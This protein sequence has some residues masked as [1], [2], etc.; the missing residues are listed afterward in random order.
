[1]NEGAIIL[2]I[3]VLLCEA[4]RALNVRPGGKYVDCTVGTG[5]HAERILEALG[6]E[7]ALLG[8]DAD[9]HALAVAEKRLREHGSQV[10][11]VNANF[12]DLRKVCERYGFIPVKG[13]LFDLGTSS[14]QLGL[15]GRGFSFQHESPLD[16]R[17]NPK[18]NVTAAHIVNTFSED[19]LVDILEKYGEEPQSRAIARRIV[20]NRPIKTT[21]ELA[22]IVVS[23]VG[24]RRGRIHPSTR[25]FQSL[26]VAVNGELTALETALPQ[27]ID[28][29]APKGRVVAIS[30]HS[31]EDRIVKSLFQKESEG[32][33]CPPKIPICV[34]GHVPR[35][36]LVNRKAIMPTSEER[37]ANPRSRSARLRVTELI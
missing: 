25:T 21:T 19:K 27:A 12:R 5:G 26:R 17:F 22:R 11:L 30:Y 34:C 8:L 16:M 37:R 24:G 9:P 3:P 13:I 2:H 4:V 7:G 1:M 23:A 33:L 29:L 32:C 15:D 36:R 35:L 18:Q 20:T 14:L 28:L 6:P 10:T 31:L